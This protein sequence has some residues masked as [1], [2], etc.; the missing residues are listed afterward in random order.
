MQE[1]EE[2]V[3][4]HLFESLQKLKLIEDR[5]VRNLVIMSSESTGFHFEFRLAIIVDAGE[6][7]KEYVLLD[8]WIPINP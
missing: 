3:E 7:T 2:T 1:T 5:K 8:R 6:L 4:G